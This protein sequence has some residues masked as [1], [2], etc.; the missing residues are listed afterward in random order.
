MWKTSCH[1]NQVLKYNAELSYRFCATIRWPLTRTR[2]AQ[3]EQGYHLRLP[4]RRGTRRTSCH[5]P[6]GA[7]LVAARLHELPCHP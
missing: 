7:T 4:R 2:A 5:A 6:A 1:A 3:V